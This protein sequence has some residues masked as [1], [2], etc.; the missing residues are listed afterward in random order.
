MGELIITFTC[1]LDYILANPQ[2]QNFQFTVDTIEG[3]LKDLLI[4][5]GFAD[6]S[7]KIH[8]TENPVK[9][10]EQPEDYSGL[11]EEMFAELAIN[12][13][14]ISDYGLSFLFD[15]QKDLVI[16]SDFTN[17]LYKVIAKIIK[18]R[19]KEQ[20]PVPEMPQPDAEGNEVPEEDRMNAQ[21]MI[22]EA[23]RAN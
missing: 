14:M 6:T 18:T 21:R 20:L 17:I 11:D 19:T 22:E 23:V 10:S 4:H 16:N 3:Y 8:L 12:R 9:N 7:L 13:Q 1:L 15:V 5:E 2:N